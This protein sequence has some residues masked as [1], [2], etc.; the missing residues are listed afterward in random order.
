MWAVAESNWFLVNKK[1]LNIT[2]MFENIVDY[3]NGQMCITL[4]GLLFLFQF[5]HSKKNEI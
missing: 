5:H 2:F 3:W 4:D 1:N